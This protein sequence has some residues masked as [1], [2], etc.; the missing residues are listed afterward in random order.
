MKQEAKQPIR[1]QRTVKDDTFKRPWGWLL[2]FLPFAFIGVSVL[3]TIITSYTRTLHYQEGLCTILAKGMDHRGDFYYAVFTV[4]V[5]MANNK[6]VRT[7]I[8]WLGDHGYQGFALASKSPD[9]EQEVLDRFQ[10]RH[11]YPCWYDPAKPTW[12]TLSLDII[13][14]IIPTGGGL[15]F[16]L[17]GIVGS[18]IC[19]IVCL[20]PGYTTVEIDDAPSKDD[21]PLK[22]EPPSFSSKTARLLRARRTARRVKRTR[23]HPWQ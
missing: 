15:L 11:I 22:T 16:S 23:K 10:V 21:A 7:E 19:L 5:H 2:F 8:D 14:F 3:I 4:Q 12:I 17:I 20:V 13:P 6:E 18:L 1:E 9:A